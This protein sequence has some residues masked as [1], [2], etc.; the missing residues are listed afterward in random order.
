MAVGIRSFSGKIDIDSLASTYTMEVLKNTFSV[1]PNLILISG[2][3]SI[4][5]SGI[6]MDTASCVMNSN[7]SFSLI[8]VSGTIYDGFGIIVP[9]LNVNSGSFYAEI[10][11][12]PKTIQPAGDIP[13]VK[14]Y[15]PYY[16]NLK[17]FYTI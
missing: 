9:R 15:Q 8:S 10:I 2:V 6:I 3:Y 1:T 16:I 13:K 17:E 11:L 4:R 12:Q 14:T 7:F 5:W